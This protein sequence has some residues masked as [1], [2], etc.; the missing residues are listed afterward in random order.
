MIRLLIS[1]G[2]VVSL[3]CS[4]P[5]PL[6]TEQQQKVSVE[7]TSEKRSEELHRNCVSKGTAV[8]LGQDAQWLDY[9]ARLEAEKNGADVASIIYQ[10]QN[11]YGVEI[12]NWHLMLFCCTCEKS[13]AATPDSGVKK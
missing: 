8:A 11:Y 4:S 6:L 9:N 2:I 12:L 13:A 1:A 3:G 10:D 5:P 7:W